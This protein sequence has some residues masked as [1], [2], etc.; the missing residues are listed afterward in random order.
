[1]ELEAE[2]FEDIVRGLGERPPGINATR[3][4]PERR[5]AD[6]V[7]VA[8]GVVLAAH[9]VAAPQPRQVQLRCLS[10][11]GIAVFD[12]L[13]RQHGD[14]VLVHLPTS[15]GRTISVVCAVM[16]TRVTAA[17]DFRLGLQ[18]RARAD[19]AASARGGKGA[20]LN[21]AATVLDAVARGERP[22]VKDDAAAR[23]RLN[24]QGLIKPA[25]ADRAST[26]TF[27]TIKD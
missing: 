1:M 9:G 17:G 4:D 8:A 2:E 5:R 7:A 13:L 6:R 16:N 20:A 11:S 19:A 3:G 22:E 24:L 26:M 25:G 10:R 12:R 27:V 15:D 23:V 21:A 18:F 14:K